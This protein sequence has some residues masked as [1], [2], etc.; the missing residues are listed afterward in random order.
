MKQIGCDKFSLFC[1]CALLVGRAGASVDLGINATSLTGA[2]KIRTNWSWSVTATNR[3]LTEATGIRLQCPIPTNTTLIQSTSSIGSI[4]TT[5]SVLQVLVSNLPAGSSVLLSYTLRPTTGGWTTNTFNLL[6][7]EPD[8]DTTDNQATVV[9]FVGPSGTMNTNETLRLSVK[10]LVFDDL[11]QRIYA[12]ERTTATNQTLLYQLDPVTLQPA[13]WRTL[14]GA[15]THLRLSADARFLYAAVQSGRAAQRMDLLGVEPDLVFE[16]FNPAA[17]L[18]YRLFDLEPYPNDS[19]TVVVAASI[20]TPTGGLYDTV[21]TSFTDGVPQPKTV[22]F[23]EYFST[24]GSLAELEMDAALGIATLA[25]DAYPNKIVERLQLTPTGVELI[26]Q[27]VYAGL[28]A[29]F[30]L[31]DGRMYSGAG[32]EVLAATGRRLR[33][34]PTSQSGSGLMDYQAANDRLLFT[35]SGSSGRV[36]VFDRVSFGRLGVINLISPGAIDSSLPLGGGQLLLAGTDGR[37]WVVANSLISNAA[38]ANIAVQITVQPPQPQV[39]QPVQ[40]TIAVTNQGPSNAVAPAITF[41]SPAAFSRMSVSPGATP[42]TGNGIFPYPLLWTNTALAPGQGKIFQV[43]GAFTKA[44]SML[45]AA[46]AA[47]SA[48]DPAYTNNRVELNLPVAYSLSPGQGGRLAMKALDA[49]YDPGRH[50]ILAI[51]TSDDPLANQL[52]AINASN[53]LIISNWTVGSMPSTLALGDDQQTLYVL[54]D[55]GSKV[56]R[57]N[58]QSMQV[59][60]VFPVAPDAPTNQNITASKVAVNPGTPGQLVAR[61]SDGKLALYA[62]D[63]FQSASDNFGSDFAFFAPDRLI[64]PKQSYSFD[65]YRY[66]IVGSTLP[67]DGFG[68][69]IQ[70]TGLRAAH[71]FVFATDGRLVNPFDLTQ[72]GA[73]AAFGT[74]TADSNANLVFFPDSGSG[75]GLRS[76]DLYTQALVKDELFGSGFGQTVADLFR[77]DGE[78][79]VTRY[80]SG[81]LIVMRSTALPLQAPADLAIG[82]NTSNAWKA[83]LTCEWFITVTN[84]GPNRA[85]ATRIDM[86]MPDG[87]YFVQA[88]V[89]AI[90]AT[91]PQASVLVGDLEPGQRALVKIQAIAQAAS[92]SAEL[93]VSTRSSATDSQQSNNVARRVQPIESSQLSDRMDFFPLAA[94]DALFDPMTQMLYLSCPN[95]SS[96]VTNQLVV[97]DP[98][99]GVVQRRLTLPGPPDRLAISSGGEY[100]YVSLNYADQV[101]RLTLP[102]LETNLMFTTLR[103]DIPLPRPDCDMVVPTGL[104]ESMVFSR[105]GGGTPSP[106]GVWIYDNGIPRTNIVQGGYGGVTYI[107]RGLSPGTIIGK[108]Y[109]TPRFRAI[110]IAADGLSAQP[111]AGDEYAFYSD[112]EAGGTNMLLG[113]RLFNRSTFGMRGTFSVPFGYQANAL[114]SVGDRAVFVAGSNRAQNPIDFAGFRADTFTLTGSAQTRGMPVGIQKLVLWGTDG[115]AALGDGYLFLGRLGLAGPPTQDSDSDGMLDDWEIAN[116]L[117]PLVADAT[118]DSDHDGASNIAEYYFGTNP[119]SA[120]SSPRVQMC[121]LGNKVRIVFPC[122]GG[123]HYYVD[124]ATSLTEPWTTVADSVSAGGM[125]F[126][127]Q[128]ISGIGQLYFRVRIS[129]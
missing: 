86:R 55:V 61:R 27:Y 52:V 63:I 18:R 14:P 91:E 58:L 12:L 107:E 36:Q 112:L 51:P 33:S 111:A 68:G 21:V 106:A 117:N 78:S 46:G 43:Q 77:A 40:F 6:A 29:G 49:I 10:Q 79:F 19:R 25:T 81:E 5:G 109:T 64:T 123:R 105:F 3:G 92:L 70:I 22:S 11:R 65:L 114:S 99:H 7:N 50:A 88:T 41:E 83:G 97:L 16:T 129:P 1:L 95:L 9:G 127:D 125:Q 96:T 72:S 121:V 82:V 69:P 42:S 17:G 74:A 126:C 39:N 101:L 13:V 110:D 57:L 15:A 75:I 60:A 54:T 35:Q 102:E 104:P 8:V 124:R 20:Q 116:G 85:A 47:D 73:F 4:V 90:S 26:A 94:N 31:V 23:R 120:D 38:T 44:G 66:R 122:A 84:L 71:G 28:A 62:N 76:F 113:D 98:A 128:Y 56:A 59:Q 45:V 67:L 89:P 115:I 53:G 32:E 108:D 103:D 2:P 48:N 119:Q 30:K 37:L 87:M 93:V 100:L 80:S 24:P 118:S 34:L